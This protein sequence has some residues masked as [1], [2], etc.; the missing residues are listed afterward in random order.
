MERYLRSFH[1]P[2]A[3]ALA[4]TLAVAG[5]GAGLPFTVAQA[6]PRAHA[7]AAA[8]ST[9]SDDDD[10][11]AVDRVPTTRPHNQQVTL[12][13]V[14]A[15][16]EAVS[17]A[18]GAML[19]RDMLVDPRVKGTITVYNDKPQPLANAYR[20][21]LAALRG[22]GFTVVES[23]GFLKVVPE[24]DAKLQTGV[25]SVGAPSRDGDQVLTQIFHLNHENPNNLVPVLRP[26]ISANNTINA[27]PSNS[28]L[29]I[30]DYA[31]NL[32]R[33]GKIIAALDQPAGA[34]FDVIQL[35]NAVASDIIQTVQR[36]IEGGTTTGGNANN[37]N[38]GL[39]ASTATSVVVE[40][41]S[42]S[43]IVR[44]AN[45]ARMAQAR[46]V[47]DKLDQPVATG[48]PA[49]NIWVVY[50]KNADATRLAEV[51]RAAMSPTGGGG[52]GSSSSGGG[53]SS[54]AAFGGANGTT[55]ANGA[56]STPT[57]TGATSG[58][59]GS[60][61]SAQTTTPVSAAARPSTGGQIQADPATNS[62]IITAP[63]P[64]YRQM[65]T[66][67][68]QLDVRR[69][70]VYVET[71]MVS[72]DAQRM[73]DFGFQWQGLFS[74]GSSFIGGGTNFT[75]IAGPSA[76]NSGD[77]LLNLSLGAAGAV[78]GSTTTTSATTSLTL[79]SNGLNI[80]F[81]PKI[82]GVYTLAAL[83]H[84]LET[85]AGGNVLS[86]PNLIAMDNEEAK[87]VVGQNIP[88]VTG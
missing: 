11:N 73:A 18:I 32:Q 75:P 63:E 7:A 19:G 47:I 35:K 48:G 77:N 50:L 49:G 80:G 15:D 85:N 58:S 51:L 83:A 22:L 27:S 13:F 40:P 44:A 25:V 33:L 59:S 39:A 71:L 26:L 31:D 2:D 12:N 17:R 45:S 65:R 36:L 67:I 57:S 21:Y 37:N 14:N 52:G 72:V 42:N 70:Q 43:L 74:A 20:S 9:T 29:V 5:A 28:S 78:S 3:V 6:A 60:T 81:V 64:Q 1:R 69:A 56:T 41:R 66:V 61:A 82:N 68:D 53:T 76:G 79:P 38:A 16:I 24:A 62:L 4:V 84:F 10:E 55:S 34:E 23:G 46:L 8:A 54:G 30:T 87:I 86:T 88:L